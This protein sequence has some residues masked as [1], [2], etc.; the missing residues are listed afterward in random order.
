M[1]WSDTVGEMAKALAA[2]QAEI[3]N[4]A[5]D[6]QN[7]FLK[8]RFTSL[9]ALLDHVRPILSANGLSISQ[10]PTSS[11]CGSL[12]GVDTMLLH[13]SGEWLVSSCQIPISAEKGKSTAQV[14]GSVITYLRRYGVASVLGVASDPDTDGALPTAKHTTTTTTGG[15]DEPLPDVAF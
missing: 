9:P 12:V 6:A 1:K 5:Q 15:D 2:V 14:A 11:D 13:T 10:H 3:T 8:N 7:P 4:P